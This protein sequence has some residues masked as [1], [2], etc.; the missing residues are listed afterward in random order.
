MVF[1]FGGFLDQRRGSSAPREDE[2]HIFFEKQD[3]GDIHRKGT[4]RVVSFDHI[5]SPNVIRN[6]ILVMSTLGT[7]RGR[8]DAGWWN[9]IHQGR[10]HA[11]GELSDPV[12]KIHGSERLPV[13]GRKTTTEV[14]EPASAA[15]Y[16]SQNSYSRYL[17]ACPCAFVQQ[18]G[19][20]GRLGSRARVLETDT[21]PARRKRNRR[22]DIHFST[23]V[24]LVKD[25]AGWPDLY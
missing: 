24:Q 10:R 21:R 8:E 19:G 17:W 3:G 5:A 7:V 25:K 12:A 20:A 1:G 23:Q 13:P 2:A 6:F 11:T 15:R 4:D 16:G 9:D 18:P 14:K 22:G